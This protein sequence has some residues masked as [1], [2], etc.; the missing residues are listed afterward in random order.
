MFSIYITLTKGQKPSFKYFLSDGNK[1]IAISDKFLNNQ[2]QCLCLYRFFHE[3][4]DVNICKTI[5]R[6]VTFGNRTVD[7]RNTTLTGTDV[8]CVTLFLISSFPKWLRLDLYLCFIQDHGLRLLNHGLFYCSDITINKL[9]LEYNG[10]TTQS[11]SLISDI[12][13]KCKVKELQLTNNNIIG[14]NEQLYFMLTNPSTTLLELYMSSTKLSSRGA[15]TLF[16]ALKNNNTLK[17]LYISANAITDDAC[18]VIT[19][20]LEKNNHLNTLNMYSNLLTTEAIMHLVNGLKFNNT[21]ALLAVPK[22]SEC[23][24]GKISS[25]QEVIL[26]R[27]DEREAVWWGSSLT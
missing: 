25:L 11:S 4:G 17:T 20:T 27:V 16:K 6:S 14:E 12:T 5:E 19:S 3:A 8:E 9:W 22:C 21:L 18:D 15:I 2:L 1:A 13:L 26:A 23:I 7:L 24:K 10:L